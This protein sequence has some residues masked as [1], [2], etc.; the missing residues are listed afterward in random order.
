MR[1]LAEAP[2]FTELARCQDLLEAW[3]PLDHYRTLYRWEEFSYWCHIAG[4]IAEL[5]TGSVRRVL[6]VGCAYGT[7]ALFVQTVHGSEVCCQD[8]ID[9]FFSPRLITDR[10]L[11]FQVSN[12]ELQPPPFPGPFDLIL[13]TEVLEHFNFHPAPT[14][15]TL[16]GLLSPDGRLLLSTPDASEWG[17]RTKYYPSLDAIPTP[18]VGTQV[19]DDHVWHYSW[20]ELE[21][22][23]RTAGL[24]VR[25]R[26]F[27]P[28][29]VGRHFNVEVVPNG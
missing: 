19:V 23:L 7:L 24:R 18:V 22:V 6:D 5:P 21:D 17:R 4:W 25:R 15:R 3:S 14:L 8:F 12:I 10:G 9:A 13:L 20:D 16:G 28:G 11:R 27:A 2:W 26:A 1:K 29:V